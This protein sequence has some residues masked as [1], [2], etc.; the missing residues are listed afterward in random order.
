MEKLINRLGL[1]EGA[2]AD[3]AS[4]FHNLIL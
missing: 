4:D 1:G 2:I 3:F